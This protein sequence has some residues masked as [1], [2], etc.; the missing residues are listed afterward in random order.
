MPSLRGLK[1]Q[2]CP[3]QA[4]AAL[5]A[6]ARADPR[7]HLGPLLELFRTGLRLQARQFLGATKL[8]PR[9]DS[10]DMTQETFVEVLNRFAGFRGQDESSLR[11]WL[12][13]ILRNVVFRLERW[14]GAECRD[15]Q[16]NVPF[17]PDGSGQVPEPADPSPSPDLLVILLEDAELLDIVRQYLPPEWDRIVRL[18]FEERLSF[19]EIGA[20]LGQTAEAVRHQCHRACEMLRALLEDGGGALKRT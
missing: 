15:P 4:F 11:T 19:A 12:R 7:T 3:E 18:H 5:L 9:F 8:R 20:R 16:R 1:D 14:Q 6:A 13:A 17:E 10:E 2:D